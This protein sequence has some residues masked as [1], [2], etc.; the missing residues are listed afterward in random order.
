M[1]S[2]SMSAVEFTEEWFES[3]PLKA[4]LG[5]SAIHGVTLGS[6]SAGTGYTLIH[7]WL[8][9]G[10][11]AHRA[12]PGGSRQ[13]HRRAGR[14][15]ARERRR[16]PHAARRR[17]DPRRPA[18]GDRRAPGQRRR[19]P[20]A[21]PSSRPPTRATRCSTWSARRN[22]RRSSSGRRSRSSMRGSVAKVHVLTDG[23]TACRPA[24]SS[25]APTLKYLER[26]YDAAKYGEISAAALSRSHDVRAP[27][28]SIHFQFAPYT[29]RARR[30]GRRGAR[31]SSSVAVDTLAA[32]LPGIQRLG[33]ASAARSRRSISSR[34]GA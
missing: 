6:M 9:R 5:A 29:L 22:C 16:S 26:A 12:V 33:A 10:G 31:T 4:A 17:A 25:I 1:R 21:R 27:L 8:N 28:V 11:L 14:R 15:I 18:A 13:H 3:E 23:R 24:R 7:N 32:A 30:L 19:D 20:R 34:P 2:L